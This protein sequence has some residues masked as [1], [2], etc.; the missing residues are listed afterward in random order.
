MDCFKIEENKGLIR[1]LNV[2]PSQQAVD[3]YV[4]NKLLYS[5][6][7]YKDFTPYVY[8]ENRPY[9]IDI[10]EAGTKNILIRTTFRLPDEDLFTLAIT[11]NIGQESL[12]IIDEDIEQ[13]I[14][15][16]QA[17]QRFVNL[18]PGLPIADVFYD[19]KP[20]VDNIDYRDQTLYEYLN[21]GQYTVSVRGNLTGE[22]I[23]KSNIQFKADRI[24]SIYI[25]GNPPNVELLQSVDGNTY[26]CPK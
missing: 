26:A 4:D 7:K 15:N 2:L 9:K 6:I 10:N 11:G 13:K 12:I 21:P 16:T 25:I 20:V 5:D 22:N 23:V 14:S 18:S 3:V 24:Y 1:Y 8:M 19:D 17:I